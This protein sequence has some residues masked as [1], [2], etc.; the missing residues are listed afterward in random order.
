MLKKKKYKEAAE[1]VRDQLFLKCYD[2]ENGRFYQGIN[3]GKPDE[4]WALDCTTWAGM[5]IFSVV[6]S[7]C[8]KTCL[9]TACEV[10]LTTDKKIVMSSETDYYNMTYSSDGTFSGFKPYSDRTA[11]YAGAPDIVWT[12]G[13]LGYAALA[14]MLS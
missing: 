7:D 5:L 13:T 6:H 9:D 12:E 11:D 10:Y 2:A 3:S 1:L 4:A 8:A 14:L